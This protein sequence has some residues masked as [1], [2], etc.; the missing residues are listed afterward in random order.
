MACRLFGPEPLPEPMLVYWNIFLW[1]WIGGTTIF[2]QDIAFENIV[3]KVMD[4]YTVCREGQSTNDNY[5][6][7]MTCRQAVNIKNIVLV[8]YH[9][10]HVPAAHLKIG[11]RYPIFNWVAVTWRHGSIIAILE[12]VSGVTYTIVVVFRCLCIPGQLTYGASSNLQPRI[13]SNVSTVCYNV[14]SRIW[15]HGHGHVTRHADESQQLQGG[16]GMCTH[17]V[18]RFI[19]CMITTHAARHAGGSVCTK[20]KLS[21]ETLRFR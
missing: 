18:E 21:R 12:M 8:A 10:I 3:C 11:Y 6:L 9:L 20:R 4:I 13:P 17:Y 14:V 2:V 19:T 1:T 15:R 5:N 7:N 16:K